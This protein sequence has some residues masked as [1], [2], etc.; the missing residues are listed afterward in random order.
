MKKLFRSFLA[1]G[2]VLGAAL[3]ASAG[4]E[5]RINGDFY[6]LP[7]RTHIAPGWSSSP[8]GVRFFPG[9]KP[10]K[11]ILELVA[12]RTGGKVAVTDLHQVGVGVL[13][14]EADVS[15]RGVASLG[16]EAYDASRRRLVQNGRQSWQLTDIPA[17]IKF[18]F[19]LND[20]AVA[21]V[22]ITLTAEAGSIARFSDVEAE[23]KYAPPPAPVTPPPPPSAP[24]PLPPPQP[25]AQ[26]LMH[27][28]FYALESLPP[29]SVFQASVPAGRDI[30][31][32]LGE[33]PSRRQYWNVVGNYDA[34]ICRVELKHKY[35][36]GMSYLK[37][38]LNAMYRGTTNVEF[39]NPAGKRVIVQFTS[40]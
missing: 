38:E 16:F 2:A 13:E 31:F 26:L 11:Q 3:C 21:F 23:M 35:K 25:A 27:D 17:K 20:P 29:V 36:H 7:S 14:V 24:A 32:K 40:L 39:V 8:G 12:H 4:H 15:G 9:N 5:L 6:G 37:V 22:R 30:D 34:R 33:H 10:G 18:N 1:A 19:T 28:G